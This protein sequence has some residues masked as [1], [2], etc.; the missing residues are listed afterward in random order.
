MLGEFVGRVHINRVDPRAL[1]MATPVR[2]LK[3]FHLL[4]CQWPHKHFK[5][6]PDEVESLGK[7]TAFRAE[8]EQT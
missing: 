6:K 7:T 8:I 5:K 2:G 1:N 3:Q 4:F